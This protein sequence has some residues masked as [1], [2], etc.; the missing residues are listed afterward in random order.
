MPLPEL[1]SV[2]VEELLRGAPP[3]TG[4]EAAVEG[5]VRE[6]RAAAIGPSPALRERVR[7]LGERAAAPPRR[8]PPVRV[9]ALA[10]VTIL[11]VSFGGYALSRPTGGDDAGPVGAG[12]AGDAGGVGLDDTK[13]L[14]GVEASGKPAAQPAWRTAE[15]ETGDAFGAP[16]SAPSDRVRDIDMS[17]EL[18][19]R[20]ADAVARAANDAMRAADALGGHVVA[21]TVDARGREGSARLTLRVPVRRLADAVVR[22]SALGAITAQNVQIQ[23]LQAGVDRRE[24]RIE[25][26]ERAIRRDELRLASGTLTA[27][28]RLEVELRVESLRAQL[29]AVGRAQAELLRRGATA[30]IQLALHTRKAAVAERDEG[31]VAGAARSGW[32]VLSTVA[33]GALFALIV[34][35]P[36]LLLGALAWALVGSRRRRLER[37][38]LDEPRPAAARPPV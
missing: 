26:L 8:R 18:R 22:L 15:A 10:A 29:R 32:N 3:D 27:K 5:L 21:S 9:L 24:N 30:E 33:G 31:G 19:V 38:L 2:R 28:E 36:L 20:D 34:T 25:A 37:R 17:L 11:V 4:R 6:L 23:D 1:E 35:S 12:G 16:V 13:A 14:D 7:A